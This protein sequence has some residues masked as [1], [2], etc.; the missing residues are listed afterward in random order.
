MDARE[1]RLQREVAFHHH[2][3]GV[4]GEEH[5]AQH[6]LNR[7]PFY[8][9]LRNHVAY[10]IARSNLSY[11]VARLFPVANNVLI[12]PCGYG[13]DAVSF[14]YVW[15][16]ANFVGLDIS[17]EAIRRCQMKDVRL[18]D[19]LKMPF[20]A[21]SFDAV[22]SNLFFHHVV[23][24]GFGP[25]LCEIARVLRPGGVLV[26][27]EQNAHHPLF[28]VTRPIR[29]VTGNITGQVEHERPILIRALTDAVGRSG[30][31]RIETFACSF[32]HQRVPTVITCVLNALLTHLPSARWASWTFGLIAWK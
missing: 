21:G 9:V 4:V 29:K 11:R 31:G 2:V 6:W 7:W 10:D 13:E 15:P 1:I 30:F 25:Y 12:A 26:T 18:G 24:D 32:G 22:I 20:V 3:H 5:L 23:D 16:N 8:S 28:L 14:G 19:I 17:P 27:M